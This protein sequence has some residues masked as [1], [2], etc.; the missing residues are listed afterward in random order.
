MGNTNAAR[1]GKLRRRQSDPIPEDDAFL[2][3]RPITGQRQQDL[4]HRVVHHA[5][6]SLR[7]RDW[8]VTPLLHDRLDDLLRELRLLSERDTGGFLALA[9]EFAVELQPRAFL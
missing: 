6:Q 1:I 7:S 4:E 3:L 8:R 9:D 2:L 5:T